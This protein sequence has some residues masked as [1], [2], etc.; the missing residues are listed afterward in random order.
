MPATAVPLELLLLTLLTLLTSLGA[1]G[2]PARAPHPA[3]ALQAVETVDFAGLRAFAATEALR[4]RAPRFKRAVF[5]SHPMLRQA[6]LSP[7]GTRIAALVEQGR[8]RSL[9]IASVL[10]PRGRRLLSRTSAD[11]VAWS[12][13][14]RWLFLA[15]PS[16]LFA[17]AMSGQGGTGA[18]AEWVVAI[19]GNLWR[20][21]V[22]LPAAAFLLESG[23]PPKASPLPKRWRLW[24]VQPGTRD[25]GVPG[26]ARGGTRFRPRRQFESST[27]RS[28]GL[29]TSLCAGTRSGDWRR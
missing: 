18:I 15:S 26:R 3:S 14:G 17:Q 6:R 16:Q 24:R 13:D 11:T 22:V 4:A 28:P 2:A 21:A 1:S 20:G 23:P 7:D 27:A 25:A 10:R 29:R 5:L 9:W 8:N 12:R 19:I